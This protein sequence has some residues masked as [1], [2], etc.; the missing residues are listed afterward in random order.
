[1][2]QDLIAYND[3]LMVNFVMALVDNI[4]SEDEVCKTLVLIRSWMEK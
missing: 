3:S 2:L 4:E 1:M